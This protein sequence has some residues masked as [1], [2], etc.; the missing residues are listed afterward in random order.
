MPDEKLSSPEL[1]ALFALMREA[2][3]VSN[4][5]L[6][7]RYGMTL[8]GRERTRMNDMKLVE[9]RKRGRS[10]AHVLTDDGW[11]RLAQ[12]IRA[13]VPRQPGSAGAALHALLGGLRAFMERSGHRLADVFGSPG[14]L[15]Q[16]AAGAPDPAAPPASSPAAPY[17]AA[18]ARVR[19]AYLELAGR[20]GTYVGLA[21]LR[22]L[23]PDLPRGAVDQTL[24]AMN[25]L[26]DV[27]IVPESNQKALRPQ[28]RE[29]A[30][31]IG[32]Q[33]KHV[34]WIGA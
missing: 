11:A 4:P 9:S 5:E 33:E 8:T 6:Q 18:E 32:D 12:E 2:G 27:N 15:P 23:L 10:F 14:A 31:T 13:G 30:V 28:D 16:A 20:P 1:A 34:L 22:E 3:E 24:R 21:E 19:A 25:R 17:T 29:A 7:E 26:E